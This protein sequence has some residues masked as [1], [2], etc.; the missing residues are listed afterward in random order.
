MFE[1][2]NNK[3]KSNVWE[4]EKEEE[5]EEEEEEDIRS[6]ERTGRAWQKHTNKQTPKK[7]N[8]FGGKYGNRKNITKRLNR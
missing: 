6:L 3:K 8:N 5:E 2:N 1:N 7:P 4:D